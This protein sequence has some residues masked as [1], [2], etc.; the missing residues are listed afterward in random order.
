MQQSVQYRIEATVKPKGIALQP[1]FG[2]L[3]LLSNN[4]QV[5]KWDS[6]I[7][8]SKQ[9]TQNTRWGLRTRTGWRTQVFYVKHATV[10]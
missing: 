7:P 3:T 2:R 1:G 9:C 4:F 10:K 5:T 8:A 6:G